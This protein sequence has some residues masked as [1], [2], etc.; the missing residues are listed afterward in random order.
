[1]TNVKAEVT[2]VNPLYSD[3]FTTIYRGV[4]YDVNTTTGKIYKAS[5]NSSGSKKVLVKTGLAVT[6]VKIAVK[7][8]KNNLK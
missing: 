7:E 2:S 5:V 6:A 3:C 8:F 1:M 4:R